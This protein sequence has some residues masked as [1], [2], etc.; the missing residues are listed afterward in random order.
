MCFAILKHYRFWAVL[1]AEIATVHRIPMVKKDIV[2][3]NQTVALKQLDDV[4]SQLG[5]SC[6]YSTVIAA[7]VVLALWKDVAHQ[8][9]MV[10]LG[11]IILVM[12]LRYAD[13]RSYMHA[14][15]WTDEHLA[16]W[17]MRLVLGAAAAGL[18]WSLTSIC[19][20]STPH[21]E[22]AVIV[23]FLIAGVS[24]FAST[25]MS[26]IPVAALTFL[27][28]SV[29]PFAL[30]LFSFGERIHLFM[31]MI[32]I[33][34]LGLMVANSQQLRKIAGAKLETEKSNIN[35][36]SEVQI[37]DQRLSN[38]AENLPGFIFTLCRS[39]QGHFSFPYT[40]SGLSEL[41]GLESKEVADD[42][43]PLSA[44]IHAE[45][46]ATVC[47]A[48]HTSAIEM[49]PLHTI[50]R[51]NTRAQGERW[52]EANAK[53]QAHM[54]NMILWHG[55]MMDVTERKQ[56]EQALLAREH[57]FRTLAENALDPIYRYDLNGRCIYANTAVER[58][59]GIPVTE[60][61]GKSPLEFVPNSSVNGCNIQGVIK[62]VLD[63]GTPRELELQFKA[64]DG[65]EVC[66]HNMIV[67][68]FDAQGSVQ[69]VLCIGRDITERKQAE[70][71]MEKTHNHLQ[72]VLKTIPDLVWLKDSEGIFL[73]CNP[74]FE[75]LYG[76]AEADIIGRTDYD[77][78]DAELADFFQTKDREAINSGRVCINEEWVT[79]AY[80]NRRALLETR[81]VPLLDGAGKVIGVLGIGRDITE[82]KQAED[83]LHEREE[84][85]NSLFNTIPIPVFYKDNEGRYQGIN[86]AFEAMF[87]ITSEQ[88]VGKSVFDI[89]PRELAEIYH[90]KDL[91]VF[92]LEQIQQYEAQISDSKGNLREVRFNKAPYYDAQGRVK[93]LIGGILDITE[94]KRSEEA[95]RESEA[96][97]RSLLDAIPIPVFYKDQE[98]R[99]LGYNKSFEIFTGAPQEKVIGKSI[100]DFIPSEIAKIHQAKDNELYTQGGVQKYEFKIQNAAGELRDAIFSKALFTDSHGEIRGLIGAAMDI[101]ELKRAERALQESFDEISALNQH[102]K[103]STQNLEKQT[104]ELE[105]SKEQLQHT[106][107]WYR[108]ILQSAPDGMLVVDGR[109]IITLV[110][111]QIGRIFGYKDDELIGQPIE[112]LV[113]PYTRSEHQSKRNVMI[114][115]PDDSRMASLGRKLRGYRKDGSEFAVDITLS[116]LPDIDGGE[117]K[118]CAAI[119]DVS[120]RERMQQTL[121]AREQESRTLIENSPDLIARYD[122]NCRRILANPAFS[123][124]AQVAQDELIGKLPTESPGG[125]DMEQL[126]AKIKEVFATGQ[127]ADMELSLAVATDQQHRMHIRLTPESNMTGEIITVLEVARDI[128]ELYAFRQKIHQ[129]AFYDT[130]TSLPNRALF[131]DRLRQMLI[132]A[133][134]HGHRAAVMMLDL[135]RFKVVNDT[136]GHPAGDELLRETAERLNRCVRGY[137]TVA[138]LGGD[139]FAVLLPEI[140]SGDDMARIASKILR[141]V[142]EPFMLESKEV[143]VSTSL[144][145]A[146][147]P[148]DSEDPNDLIRQADSA[149]YFA[150]RL[151]RN[152][153]RFYSKDLTISAEEKLTLESELRRAIERNELEL[154]YQPKIFLQD[155]SMA[156]SEALLRWNNPQRGLVLPDQFIGIAEDSGLIVEI[157]EWVLFNACSTASA[158]N[159]PDKPLH[160]VAINLSARQFQTGDLVKTVRNVLD[161]TACD[162]EWIELEITESLLLDEYGDVLEIL[163][164]FRAIGISIAIDDFGTGYSS[165]SYLTR[166]PINTLKIDRSFIHNITTDNY[167]AELVKAIISIAHC[168]DQ[169]VVAEGVE[170]LEQAVFLQAS[171]CQ[172]SQGYLY[173]KPVVKTVFEKLPLS[174]TTST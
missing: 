143:F 110:N 35:L 131:N 149:M 153:F 171:G 117:G 60:L 119:R 118:I 148:N 17:R 102:L 70:M 53:P 18:C 44:M 133:R 62:A 103:E 78:V 58:L 108:S 52:I 24:A 34:Y 136:L 8:T 120:E 134:W 21:D 83:A 7:L 160:K 82:R 112:V 40:S 91:E 74:N 96:F 25:S 138:R 121:A 84:F 169:Q 75:R 101:S 45:D 155:G 31:G 51:A 1:A 162:A 123:K 30:W 4:Y 66:I 73:A 42:M 38:M 76:A 77:F 16:Q 43:A 173:S 27:L 61:L 19:F 174:F 113:P 71:A 56:M 89:H 100:F 23:I 3:S 47:A 6:I 63:S 139:E 57:E 59:T 104:L 164:A 168:L 107:A 132:D 114:N 36:L 54:G 159:G 50:F 26:H 46:Q 2:W 87:C 32:A 93:G 12:G 80:N 67:P 167:H 126:E 49:A 128:T 129:M 172:M 29:L 170:T 13:A 9:L 163:N 144:G 158:W 151:G 37:V 68:E 140:R 146:V 157:G 90:A 5:Y 97:L 161:E 150:K 105:D 111:A 122:Q 11:S 165:L 15:K 156:G 142:N 127:P 115:N 41:F 124:I 154:Y 20:L 28:C 79:F 147:Y 99:Y 152:N 39:H 125:A 98:G 88:L 85:L 116:R 145:I 141:A 166:F 64:T 55:V 94:H 22:A 72:A 33:S 95:L 92:E 135:D 69:G 65:R 109:G 106:E 14:V 130:L 86:P 48:I 81:K 137:D 10:W